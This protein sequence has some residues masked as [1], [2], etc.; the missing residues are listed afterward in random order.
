MF[1]LKILSLMISYSI[2]KKQLRLGDQ[3]E[4]YYATARTTETIGIEQLADHI[5]S[6]GCMYGKADFLAMAELF[7]KAARE[8]LLEGYRVKLGGIGTIYLKLKSEGVESRADF[9][10]DLITDVQVSI[11][12]GDAFDNLK[13]DATFGQVPT[14]AQSTLM[15][16][17]RKQGLTAQDLLSAVGLGEAAEADSASD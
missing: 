14:L 11:L 1:N 15:H 9:T 7:G 17:A 8:M 13:A 4:K 16:E 10:A 5:V 12:P 3:G 2:V 6:H